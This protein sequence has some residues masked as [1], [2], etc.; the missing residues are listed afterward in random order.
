M[1]QGSSFPDSLIRLGTISLGTMSGESSGSEGGLQIDVGRAEKEEPVVPKGRKAVVWEPGDLV[2]AKVLGF[3]F[4]PAKVTPPCHL[5][6][7]NLHVIVCT[8]FPAHFLLV[9]RSSLWLPHGSRTVQLTTRLF[10]QV[11]DPDD[12][13][14]P[15]WLKDPPKPTYVLARFFGT[16]D[17]WVC[18]VE[19]CVIC[20]LPLC[21]G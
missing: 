17:M 1:M 4:W 13:I 8:S 21:I 6:F 5:F 16:Y 20:R 15:K 14:I 10:P 18:R 9:F 19:Q 3:N 12:A 2:W 7:I 11:L